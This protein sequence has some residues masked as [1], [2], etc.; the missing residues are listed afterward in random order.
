MNS[1]T[2]FSVALRVACGEMVT[3]AEARSVLAAAAVDRED[4]ARL[5]RSQRI[6]A[7]NEALRT[8]AAELGATKLGAWRQAELLEA[9]VRRFESRLWPRLRVGLECAA[10]SPSDEALCRAFLS[11]L[12]VPR[13]QR[14][15][16]ELLT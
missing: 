13:T 12:P 11:G 9:A 16:Y 6:K 10:L 15:L 8:A 14:R 3:Q 7:R 5:D 2:P 4:A 1:A